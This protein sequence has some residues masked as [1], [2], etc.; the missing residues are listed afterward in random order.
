MTHLSVAGKQKIY[1]AKSKNFSFLV[2]P[3]GPEIS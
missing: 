3:Q 2:I 1:L